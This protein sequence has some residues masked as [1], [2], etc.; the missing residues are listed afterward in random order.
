MAQKK[1]LT[2]SLLVPVINLSIAAAGVTEK[3]QRDCG[4]ACERRGLCSRLLFFVSAVTLK[5]VWAADWGLAGRTFHPWRAHRE[6]ERERESMFLL[7]LELQYHLLIAAAT[8]FLSCYF[9]KPRLRCESAFLFVC[10]WH[11]VCR[12]CGCFPKNIVLIHW[13]V[14]IMS[15]GNQA[16]D[17]FLQ[18]TPNN[19]SLWLL[20]PLNSLPFFPFHSTLWTN[21][22]KPIHFWFYLFPKLF[23]IT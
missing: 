20:W 23:K 10:C 2:V 4:E 9:Y 21:L 6:G 11:F 8:H 16:N 5:C 15:L 17:K 1:V 12:L 3:R 18:L 13:C 22:F 19:E 7:Y 14:L